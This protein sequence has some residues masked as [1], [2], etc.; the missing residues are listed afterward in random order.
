MLAAVWA[1]SVAE[2]AFA[3]TRG[4]AFGPDR[5]LALAFAVGCPLLARRR[6]FELVKAWM[7]RRRA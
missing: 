6:L 7:G 1:L 4:D 2:V 3:V 5:G